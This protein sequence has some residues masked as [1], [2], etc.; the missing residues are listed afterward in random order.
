MIMLIRA[1]IRYYWDEHEYNTHWGGENALNLFNDENNYV[2][3]P[4]TTD[5]YLDDFDHIL[6]WPPYPDAK[7]GVSIYAGFDSD[8]NRHINFAISKRDPYPFAEIRKKLLTENFFKVETELE[9][10]IEPFLSD[11]G[12]SL[13]PNELWYRARIGYKAAYQRYND[14]WTSEIWLQPWAKK[15]IGAPPPLAAGVGRL[16]RSGVSMLYLASD[17]YT[18]IAEIRPHPGHHVSTGAF[19][20]IEPVRIADFDPDISMLSDNDER[21]SLYAI[22]KAFDRLMS[23]PVTPD[24]KTPYLP[25]QLLAEILVRRGF[26]GVRYQSSVSTGKNICIFHPEKFRFVEDYSEVSRVER[27]KY[28]ITTAPSLTEP[29][30]HDI[31]LRRRE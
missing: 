2:I 3:T 20:S 1:L 8:G 25:T 16:N 27:V 14:G 30:T 11:I 28:G 9:S 19:M 21:L 4:P 22:I 12:F 18:A 24:E 31:L 17:R 6:Q 5:E 7:E 29:E 26:D 10:M 13:L 15:E 23:L